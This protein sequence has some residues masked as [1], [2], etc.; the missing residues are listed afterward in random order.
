MHL[1]IVKVHLERKAREALLDRDVG[2]DGAHVRARQH[3]DIP[4]QLLLGN[5]KTDEARFGPVVVLWV[6]VR[7]TPH[8]LP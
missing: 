2:D 7:G 8:P 3:I 1:R 5:R 6:P 4:E